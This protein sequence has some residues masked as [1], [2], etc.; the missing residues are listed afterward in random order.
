M[1]AFRFDGT[2]GRWTWRAEK[3][4]TAAAR[5][6][7]VDRFRTLSKTRQRHEL[8]GF[9]GEATYE[10]KLSE[11][12][13]WLAPGELLHL[14]KHTAWGSGRYELCVEGNSSTRDT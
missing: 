8:S 5:T 4:R 7:S 3:P 9:A 6:E 10:G 1:K 11:F 2:N 14:G 12:L 13:P